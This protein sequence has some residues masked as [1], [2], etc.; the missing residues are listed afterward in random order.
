[1]PGGGKG[2]GSSTVTVNNGPVTVDADSTVEIK[3]LDDIKL[4]LQPTQELILPQP[5]KTESKLD[6]T[7]D[8]TS[9]SK[10]AMAIDL[11]PVALDVCL[12]TSTKLPQG[13]ICQPF[14]YHVGLTMFGVE[15]FGLNFGGESRIVMQ[16]LPKKPVVDWPAQ[17][18]AAAPPSTTPM[19]DRPVAGAS[20]RG[21]RVRVK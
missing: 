8:V 21:L 12:N 4:T 18:N 5:F 16:D 13:Q 3:G 10:S 17:Q 20:D 15:Y 9:D 19:R 11:K 6:T 14:S 2:G 7:S 1:M